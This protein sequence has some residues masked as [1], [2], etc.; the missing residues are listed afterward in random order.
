MFLPQAVSLGE[1]TACV[2]IV[3]LLGS[4]FFVDLTKFTLETSVRLTVTVYSPLRELTVVL[5]FIK[6]GWKLVEISFCLCRHDRAKTSIFILVL[7][8]FPPVFGPRSVIFA[9]FPPVDP[10]LTVRTCEI[11]GRHYR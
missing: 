1:K 5:C 10:S 2:S 6:I 8:R 3:L 7:A 9:G 11:V 4:T